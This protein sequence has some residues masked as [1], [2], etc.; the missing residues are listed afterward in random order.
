MNVSEEVGQNFD[1]ER[2][3]VIKM[4]KFLS[5]VY[6]TLLFSIKPSSKSTFFGPAI[7]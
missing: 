5:K 4:K 7:A 1:T 2:I 3:S 6:F